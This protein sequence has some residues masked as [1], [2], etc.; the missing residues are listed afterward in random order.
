MFSAKYF[1]NYIFRVGKVKMLR[2]I[3]ILLPILQ[4]DP[5]SYDSLSSLGCEESKYPVS[6]VEN[7][8][9]SQLETGKSS[10]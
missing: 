4:L 8:S 9:A 7:F 3:F 2:C 1:V 6:V 5:L 10:L